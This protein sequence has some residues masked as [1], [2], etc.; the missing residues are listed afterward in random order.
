MER[1]RE[2]VRSKQRLDGYRALQSLLPPSSA[3]IQGGHPSPSP[4]NAQPPLGSAGSF[5][6]QMQLQ[7]GG[8]TT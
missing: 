5:V 2:G 8:G 3:P 6:P 4:R 7:P 1:E